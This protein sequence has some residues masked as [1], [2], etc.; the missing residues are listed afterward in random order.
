VPEAGVTFAV[1]VTEVPLATGDTGENVGAD[2]VVD[3]TGTTG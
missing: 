2:V 3:G 1:N